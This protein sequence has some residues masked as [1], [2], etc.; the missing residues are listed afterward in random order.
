MEGVNLNEQL[1]TAC[2][3][4]ELAVAAILLR[5]GAN[6]SDQYGIPIRLAAMF[7]HTEIVRILLA[8]KRLNPVEWYIRDSI[9]LAERKGYTEI[10]EMLKTYTNKGTGT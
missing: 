8:D 5:L 6:P 7:G 1:V 2:A 10:A 4:G 3:N 9:E